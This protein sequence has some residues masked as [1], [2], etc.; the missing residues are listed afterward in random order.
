MR[1]TKLAVALALGLVALMGR[2]GTAQT[3]DTIAV[4]VSLQEVLSVSVSPSTWNIGP[5]APSGTSGPTSF[6]A[7]VGNTATRLEILGA[8]GAGGWLINNTVGLNQFVV[9]VTSPSLTLSAVT[10]QELAP[11]VPAYG[12]FS[13]ELT[14]SAPSSDDKGAGTDQSFAITVRASAPL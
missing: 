8:D 1:S 6:T 10:Y 14:Y 9:A 12:N 5:I 2:T 3:T 11:S 4:T 7:T 13:F